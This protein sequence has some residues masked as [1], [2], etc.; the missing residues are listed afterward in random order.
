M[1]EG[2]AKLMELTVQSE[3]EKAN[4]KMDLKVLRM[5]EDADNTVLKTTYDDLA[6]NKITRDQARYQIGETIR[7]EYP[8]HM[9]IT[10]EQDFRNHAEKN[11]AVYIKHI[12]KNLDARIDAEPSLKSEKQIVEKYV[13]RYEEMLKKEPK[14]PDLIARLT[15]KRARLDKANDF[16]YTLDLHRR[17]IAST[18]K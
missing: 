10:Y 12:S 11:W 13:K 15:E 8:N 6:A 1:D 5:R 4:P 14:N 7:N 17:Q 16:L 3:L 9:Q 18:P 2:E